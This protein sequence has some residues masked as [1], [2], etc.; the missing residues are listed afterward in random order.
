MPQNTAAV[1][2]S[3]DEQRF[4]REFL[5]PILEWIGENLDPDQVF[6]D[7]VLDEWAAN[8]GWVLAVILGEEES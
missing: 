1:T 2:S 8:N 5:D 6:P 7:V 4:G 3:T